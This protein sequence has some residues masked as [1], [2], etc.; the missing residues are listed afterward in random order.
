MKTF[1]LIAA[2]L[3]LGTA[4]I[5]QSSTPSY[6]AYQQTT[7]PVAGSPGTADNSP[8]S[9][10]ALAERFGEPQNL[11]WTG[12]KN[13]HDAWF[14]V[15]EKKIRA[16]FNNKKEFVFS[17]SSYSSGSFLPAEVRQQI[18]QHYAD[19]SL[20]QVFEIMNKG[21]MKFKILLKGDKNMLTLSYQDGEMAELETIKLSK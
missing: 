15:G 7:L 16:H 19:R 5:A 20:F 11:R 12:D 1:V 17:L 3:F 6:I 9:V 13:G 4:I 14:E 18:E 2:S 21:A 10:E 8:V